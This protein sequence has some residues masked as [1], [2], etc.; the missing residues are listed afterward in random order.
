MLKIVFASLLAA[1]L[2]AATFASPSDAATRRKHV[3]RQQVEVVRDR[4][5]PARYGMPANYYPA[6]PF[7]FFL[8]PG[9]WWLPAHS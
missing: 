9:P 6:P 1:A 4:T 3:E 5:A 7:P 2:V 8:L